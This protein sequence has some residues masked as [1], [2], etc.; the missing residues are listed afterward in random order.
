MGCYKIAICDDNDS[1][2]NFVEAVIL[3]YSKQNAI[4][5]IIDSFKSGEELCKSMQA[6]YSPQ[7]LFLDIKMKSLSGVEVGT[8]IRNVRKDN[9]IQIV[10]ISSHDEYVKQLFAS[11]PLNFLEKPLLPE[12]ITA[13]INIALE[14]FGIGTGIFT[15]SKNREVFKVPIKD[16]L[17]FEGKGKEVLMHTKGGVHQFYSTLEGIHN[18]VK[19]YDFFYSHK[20]YLVSYHRVIKFCYNKIQLEDNTILPVSTRKKSEIQRFRIAKEIQ[21]GI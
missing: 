21:E 7:L 6:G 12:Q 2:L 1:V 4:A 5:M 19:Q 10:Y 15:Y 3:Q 9:L 20:S 13:Q 17:F 8:Y 11:R 16:I 18:Q 14:L